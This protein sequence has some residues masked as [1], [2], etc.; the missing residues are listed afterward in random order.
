MIPV[1][2]A[3]T[4]AVG[5]VTMNAVTFGSVAGT[6]YAYGRKVGRVICNTLDNF[7]G[8]ITNLVEQ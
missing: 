1:I 5:R 8:K 6:S 2:L 3:T 7:E 4:F